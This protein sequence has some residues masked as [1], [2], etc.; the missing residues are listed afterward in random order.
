MESM[1]EYLEEYS[2]YSDEYEEQN[3]IEIDSREI[4][5]VMD[6]MTAGI[7]SADWDKELESIGVTIPPRVK[8]DNIKRKKKGIVKEK[9]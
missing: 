5:T 4:E 1:L 9:K 8:K 2:Q 3:P 6:N 7:K